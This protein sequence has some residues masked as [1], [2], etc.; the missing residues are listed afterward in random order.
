MRFLYLSFFIVLFSCSTDSDLTNDPESAIQLQ[1]QNAFARKT[2]PHPAQNSSNPYDYSGQLFDSLFSAYHNADE[3]PFTTATI[4]ARV[5]KVAEENAQFAS[6]R[7]S[8]YTPASAIDVSTLLGN[9]INC[10]SDFTNASGLSATGKTRLAAF[11]NGVVPVC[12]T[13]TDY[14]VVHDYISSFETITMQAADLTAYDKEIMLITSSITR[15]S[16]Y[17]KPKKPKKKKEDPEWDLLITHVTA[18]AQAAE[19]GVCEAT[20]RALATGIT[21]QP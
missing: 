5:N 1:S 19:I 4:V 17:R 9:P 16:A 15:Y 3:L 14:G 6:F 12:N 8:N 11:I 10:V 20:S 13:A 18:G 7:S 2:E 21:G